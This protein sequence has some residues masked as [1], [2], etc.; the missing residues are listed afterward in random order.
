MI[1]I[2]ITIL[3]NF[4][5]VLSDLSGREILRQTGPQLLNSDQ[6]ISPV[7][8]SNPDLI[9]GMYMLNIYLKTGN[10]LM[11]LYGSYQILKF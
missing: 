11:G 1:Q 10:S 6:T 8:S 4:E 2:K 7:F 3:Y 9:S 5:F